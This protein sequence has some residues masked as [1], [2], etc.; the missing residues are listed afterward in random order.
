M[1]HS[2]DVAQALRHAYLFAEMSEP[3]LQA[4][5][6]GMAD[7]HLEPGKALFRQGQPAERFY[8]LREGL[9]KLFRLSPDGD[10]KIIEIMRPGET[11]AEAVMF[12]G[13][14]GRYPVNAEAINESRVYAF[15]QKV[16][17]NLLRESNE[18]TF[19]LLASM[20]RRLHMLVNQ[21]ESLTLQNAT[22]R[23]VAYLLEQ[24][25]RDVKTSP[26]VQLTTPKGVIASRL[27][28][29][30]ETLSRILGKLRQGGLIEVHGHHITIR[31][32]QALR[33]TVHL[34]PQE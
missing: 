13:P 32:V 2:P 18:A 26:E 27:A 24:I 33:D 5:V 25:P 34:P 17:L 3:H 10:E 19:G 20:S 23:L 31:N 22:Y 9:V 8:F 6:Q 4:L 1:N 21:I 14:Q 7:I 11:F 29:Q 16:F 15:E 12:M 30:P 28:I